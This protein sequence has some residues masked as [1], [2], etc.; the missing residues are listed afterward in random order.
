MNQQLIKKVFLVILYTFVISNAAPVDK[1]QYK[2]TVKDVCEWG[3]HSNIDK[4]L[5]MCE[6]VC[7][8]ASQKINRIF[9]SEN[10]CQ[11]SCASKYIRCFQE[12]NKTASAV[13]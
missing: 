6:A 9:D 13:T 7:H 8:L 12:C 5:E 4:K 3:C 10:Q 2:K 1:L 11:E